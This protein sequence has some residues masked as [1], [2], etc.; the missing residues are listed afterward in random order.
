MGLTRFPPGGLRALAVV[1]ALLY[2]RAA[3]FSRPALAGRSLSPVALSLRAAPSHA[4]LLLA[5]LSAARP[6]DAT[7]VAGCSSGSWVNVSGFTS[8]TG[9]NGVYVPYIYNSAT[10]LGWTLPYASWPPY[11]GTGWP[12]GMTCDLN[13]H[14]SGNVF[15]DGAFIP[16]PRVSYCCVLTASR[17][18]YSIPRF[19]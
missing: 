8:P 1:L 13:S 2:S 18:A 19:L 14:F 6:G 5:L 9:L 3:R 11:S 7:S 16:R 17:R 4:L 10:E 15:P 12:G